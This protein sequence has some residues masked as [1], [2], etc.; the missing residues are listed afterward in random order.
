MGD[1]AGSRLALGVCPSPHAHACG[2]CGPLAVA[3]PDLFASVALYVTRHSVFRL[4]GWLQGMSHYAGHHIPLVLSPVSRDIIRRFQELHS[5]SAAASWSLGRAE[6]PV[7]PEETA[8]GQPCTP[9]SGKPPRSCAACRKELRQ[10]GRCSPVSRHCGQE[11]PT[12][13]V[14]PR[15][16]G[17]LCREEEKAVVCV[18][19][20]ESLPGYTSHEV[21]DSTPLSHSPLLVR[22]LR[23]PK[24]GG[25][26]RLYDQP[27]QVVRRTEVLVCGGHVTPGIRASFCSRSLLPW[28]GA[29]SAC[30]RGAPFSWGRGA[31]VLGSPGLAPAPRFHGIICCELC[32]IHREL[33]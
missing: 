27:R 20:E 4:R 6:C 14:V 23:G 24:S 10:H 33:S 7:T 5:G 26:S 11:V 16:G 19:G 12:P 18:R 22:R 1:P 8:A 29:G 28:G 2:G 32:W 13:R 17:Q 31:S 21:G 3:L 25:R 9:A 30:G 15:D